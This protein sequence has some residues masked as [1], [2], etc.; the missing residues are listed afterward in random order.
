MTINY[1][2]TNS[3]L[4]RV[5]KST[6]KKMDK[7][8]IILILDNVRSAINVGSIFRTADA[9]KIE[10]IYLCGITCRPPHKEL[11]KSA[12]GSTESVDWEYR[13]NTSEL[14]SELKTNKNSK[15]YT[16]EQ[17]EN[18]IYLDKFTPK[19]DE[20]TI[21]ISASQ[22]IRIWSSHEPFLPVGWGVIF[23]FPICISITVLHRVPDRDKFFNG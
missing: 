2:T 6:Y 18:S 20:K 1:K 23:P 17:T 7:T 16:V 21:L 3:M 5:D 19:L 14:V 15:I 9:F 8:L 4:L 13:T 12:L 11:L 10:K 22:Q